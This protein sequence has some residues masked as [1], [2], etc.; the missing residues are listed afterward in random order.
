MYDGTRY[1]GVP[2][3]SHKH[4][5]VGVSQK[6]HTPC[7]IQSLSIPIFGNSD[8]DVVYRMAALEFGP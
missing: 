1:L 7:K 6:S 4:L 8:F 5:I 3:Q 2:A